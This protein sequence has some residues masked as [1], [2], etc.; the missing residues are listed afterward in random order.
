MMT[1]EVVEEMR[2]YGSESS[3]GVSYNT[4]VCSH[5]GWVTRER[6]NRRIDG[7]LVAAGSTTAARSGLLRLQPQSVN[8]RT[9]LVSSAL[10]LSVFA[11]FSPSLL[12]SLRGGEEQ[13]AN[14]ILM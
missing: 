1:G 6:K 14:V 10:L 11:L 5:G 9:A 13:P 4:L 2:R 8:G 7:C 3:C 12:C